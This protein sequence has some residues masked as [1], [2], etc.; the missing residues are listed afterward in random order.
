MTDL[1][2][3]ILLIICGYLGPIDALR[4][5][6]SKDTS[7]RFHHLIIKYRTHIKLSVLSYSEFRYMIDTILPQLD[8]SNLVLSNLHIPCLFDEFISSLGFSRLVQLRSLKLIGDIAL[9]FSSLHWFSCLSK[10]ETLYINESS[11]N[12][13]LSNSSDMVPLRK[14]LFVNGL[15]PS[16]NEI[17]FHT[18]SGFVLHNQLKSFKTAQI[19]HA[20]LRLDTADDLQILLNNGFLGN[21][22]TLYVHLNAKQER[23][24]LRFTTIEHVRTVSSL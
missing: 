6:L 23:C 1:P 12:R 13:L 8:P 3:E 4:A 14:F 11:K 17:H 19:K 5:F 7:D 24:K 21:V 18:R 20:S 2:D 15:P 22:S 10:L 9:R 16:V